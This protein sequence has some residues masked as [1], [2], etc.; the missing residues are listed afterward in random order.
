MESRRLGETGSTQKSNGKRSI[1]LA[2]TLGEGSCPATGAL[3]LKV[4]PTTVAFAG[5]VAATSLLLV[6]PL[7]P[8]VAM[9]I[10]GAGA[11]FPYPLYAKWADAY[12][13]ET[14]TI[15]IYQPIGSG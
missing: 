11:T 7:S 3:S 8:A 10:S 15:V 4:L 14:G 9:E 1:P 2:A 12:K 5:L 6:A 13:K